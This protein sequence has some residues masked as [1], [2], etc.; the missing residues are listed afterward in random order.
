MGSRYSANIDNWCELAARYGLLHASRSLDLVYKRRGLLSPRTPITHLQ[1]NLE[2]SSTV[3]GRQGQ[4]NSNVIPTYF[5]RLGS[6]S[7]PIIPSYIANLLRAF[8]YLGCNSANN[9]TGWGASYE[10]NRNSDLSL[11]GYTVRGKH[12]RTF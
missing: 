11:R 10:Q 4:I 2:D 12:Q 5:C 1:Q 9:T 8:V 3:P 6:L 7:V